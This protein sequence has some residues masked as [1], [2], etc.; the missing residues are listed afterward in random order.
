[1]VVGVGENLEVSRY[2]RP[3]QFDPISEFLKTVNDG[4]VPG[5][6]LLFDALAV[7][8]PA[9]I[10]EVRRNQVKLFLHLPRPGHKRCVSQR[11][12]DVVLPEHVRESG[13]EPVLVSSLD[14]KFVIRRQLLQEGCQH[15][16]K[17]ILLR[18]FPAVEERKLKDHRTELWTENIYRFHE[19][20]EFGIAI[21]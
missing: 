1:M 11:Q 3:K 18:E 15:G 19:L 9:Y 10:S 2:E 6:C 14:C 12:R 21:H 8:K 16:E 13:I 4:F 17:T 5:F 7:T 20:F